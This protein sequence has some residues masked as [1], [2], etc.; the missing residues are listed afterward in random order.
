[1][2]DAENPRAASNSGT[3]SPASRDTHKSPANRWSSKRIVFV[4]G[5]GGVGKSLVAAA[6]AQEQANA[7]RRVLLAEI[8]DVSY[9]K[10]FW[11]LPVVDHVPRKLDRGFDLA[12]WSGESSLREYVLF[13]LKI[14]TLYRLFF[15]NRVMRSLVN[16]APGLNEISILGKV[17]SGLRKVGPQLD[18]DL[19]VV[20]SYATGH[21]MALFHSPRGLMEAIQIGPMG[22][23]SREMLKIISDHELC[24]YE[25][26][27]LLEELPVVE[28]LEF[29]TSLE[30]ELGLRVDV[31][32]NKVMDLPLGEPSLQE[33]VRSDAGGGVGDF[34]RYLIAVGERQRKFLKLLHEKV[35]SVFEIPLVF[36]NDAD[37]LV[38]RATEA[39]RKI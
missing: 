12:L 39:L 6:I 11:N 21:A 4:T 3:Q 8:G 2:T 24:A 17:T 30:A 20:D 35:G 7:G 1:M 23:H 31:I 38:D 5:K 13:Y 19:I 9:F 16:V 32:A 37:A 25:V 22:H 10:D 26:V 14:E 18:Y 34:S 27:T 29:R 28:T 33:L 36:S 15:E